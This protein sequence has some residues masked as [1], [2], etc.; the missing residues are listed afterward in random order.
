MNTDVKFEIYE[1]PGRNNIIKKLS[2]KQPKIYLSF[3][4]NYGKILGSSISTLKNN[5]YQIIDY[6]IKY[7][8]ERRKNKLAP[9]VNCRDEWNLSP[10]KIKVMGSRVA[11][12]M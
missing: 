9:K 11:L 6:Q 12:S 3:M 7:S 5:N 10:L 1:D 8:K 4:S 2:V